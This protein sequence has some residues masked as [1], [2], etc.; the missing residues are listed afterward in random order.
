MEQAVV[1]RV[2][3]EEKTQRLEGLPEGVACGT[4]MVWEKGAFQ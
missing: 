2:K 1:F 3:R 4:Q